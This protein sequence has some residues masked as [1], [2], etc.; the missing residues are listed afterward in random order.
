MVDSL[1]S[2]YIHAASKDN[3]Q[4]LV[5]ENSQRGPVL[6]NFWSRK[7]GPCLRQYPVLDKLIHNYAGRVLLIN[8][9]ADAEVQLTKEY[10]ISSVPTLKLFRHAQIVASRHG[11]QS[12]ADLTALLEQ[13][14]A[15]ES[16]RELANAVQLFSEGQRREAYDLIAAAIVADPVNPRLPLTMGKLLKFEERYVEALKLLDSLPDTLRQDS[17]IDRLHALLQFHTEID[18]SRDIPTLQAQ[19]TATPAATDIKVALIAQYVV[20]QQY[21]PALELLLTI[22]ETEPG[23]QQN[24]A[25]RAMLRLIKLLGREHPLISQY[26][27]RIQR[28][29]H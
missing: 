25:Q 29:A 12:E 3:F 17:E 9:D 28:Y 22:I 7:A 15:R 4:T 20:A 26:R 11:Y 8:V 14:V 19:L 24:Y 1:S 16:D 27:S 10:G 13:Y 23:Y 21:E 5:L 6:V 2:A 18:T